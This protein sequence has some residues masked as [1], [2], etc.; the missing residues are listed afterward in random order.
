MTICSIKFYTMENKRRN[1]R[2]VLLARLADN[3]VQIEEIPN[4]LYLFIY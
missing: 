1:D 4:I 3:V 2:S